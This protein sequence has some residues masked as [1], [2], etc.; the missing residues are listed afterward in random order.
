MKKRNKLWITIGIGVFIFFMIILISDIIE[1]GERI[2]NISKYLEY[3]FYGLTIILF[4][5]LIINPLRI[6]LFSPSFSIVTI[7]DEDNQRNLKVYKKIVKTLSNNKSISE[8]DKRKL[9]SCE[10]AGELRE[11]LAVVFND[12]IKKDINKQK[13]FSK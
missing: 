3:G 9:N 4:Y 7:L 10:T 6:I 12:T 11:E 1:T 8:E 2:R 5:F 13:I